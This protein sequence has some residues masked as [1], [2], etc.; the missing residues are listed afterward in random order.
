MAFILVLLRLFLQTSTMT[1]TYIAR[2]AFQCIFVFLLFTGHSSSGQSLQSMTWLPGRNASDDQPVA[3]VFIVGTPGQGRMYE[4]PVARFTRDTITI[5][6][7]YW[8]GELASPKDFTD[9][10][11]IGILPPGRYTLIGKTR[12]R[13]YGG[14]DS[15]QCRPKAHMLVDSITINEAPVRPLA[16]DITVYPSP[17]A[18]RM[19]R[20][21]NRSKAVI[22]TVTVFNVLGQQLRLF[23]KPTAMDLNSLAA[24]IYLLHIKT[25]LGV[26]VWKQVLQ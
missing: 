11:V 20:I 19:V 2:K 22:G 17:S 4:Q 8:R 12:E 18:N 25:D 24:G 16:A 21:R 14:T 26:L 7:C 10:V 6:G 13:L 3:V 5:E 15:A 9:T 1:N 23:E